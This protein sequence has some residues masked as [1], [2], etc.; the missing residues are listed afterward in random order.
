MR[1]PR[2]AALAP[3]ILSLALMPIADAADTKA[4]EQACLKAAIED[5]VTMDD[6]AEYIA[7]CIE[8]SGESLEGDPDLTPDQ[9]G[10]FDPEGDQ[11]PAPV[12]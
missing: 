6:R 9:E 4:I 10:D 11:E 1:T 8:E 12:D 5:H 2:R 7:V 3:M